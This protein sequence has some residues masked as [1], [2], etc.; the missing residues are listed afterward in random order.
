MFGNG[1]CY[2]FRG[3][4][5]LIFMMLRGKPAEGAG[6]IELK[7][8]IFLALGANLCFAVLPRFLLF[9]KGGF[10]DLDELQRL[11]SHFLPLPSTSFSRIAGLGQSLLGFPSCFKWLLGW[12]RRCFPLEHFSKLGLAEL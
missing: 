6:R 2:Y 1:F 11:S 7:D 10:R 12:P 3:G 8:V 4:L 5:L 9:F